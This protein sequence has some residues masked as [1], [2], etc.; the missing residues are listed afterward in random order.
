MRKE[1]QRG[2]ERARK[3][4][5]GK[6]EIRRT[7]DEKGRYNC[8]KGTREGLLGGSWL[9]MASKTNPQASPSLTNKHLFYFVS[10]PFNKYK[11]QTSLIFMYNNDRNFI[12]ILLNLKQ[13]QGRSKQGS[14]E[15]KRR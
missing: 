9:A 14:D 1:K 2:K 6:T 10:T 5:S 11:I 15:I 3:Q 12:K 13:K 7:G 4:Q 8:K